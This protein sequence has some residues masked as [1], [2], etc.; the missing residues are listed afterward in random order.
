[1]ATKDVAMDTV[2][3]ELFVVD[4]ASNEVDVYKLTDTGTP[5]AKIRNITGGATALNAPSGVAV[6]PTLNE[7]YIVNGADGK[8][9]VFAREANGNA[10]P[11]RNVTLL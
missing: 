2:H 11:L 4:D 3:G 6:N 1:M 10:V 7:L 9:L 8:L 5:G